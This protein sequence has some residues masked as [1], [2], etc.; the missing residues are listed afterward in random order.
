MHVFF[1]SKSKGSYLK[2]I[3]CWVLMQ[4]HNFASLVIIWRHRAMTSQRHLATNWP[5]F[6]NF[7]WKIV[8]TD[9]HIHHTHTHTHSLC[10]RAKTIKNTASVNLELTAEQW[11][12]KYEK[13]KEKNK[14]LKENIQ[15]LEAELNHWRNSEEICI[16]SLFLTQKHSKVSSEVQS[17]Q[18]L[19][20][21]E[22]VPWVFWTCSMIIL[23][24]Y[25][26][27]VTLDHKTSHEGQ[28]FLIEIY[29]SSEIWINNLSI[30]VWFVRIG[31]Y[32]AEIQLFE[33][34]ES[35]GAKK[36]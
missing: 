19:F 34:L 8:G 24:I 25:Q 15:S 32:L 4:W 2:Y 11:K 23:M 17:L 12:R 33:N 1:T 20:T 10:L 30:D 13:E 36:I 16:N 26:I 9:T 31:Q 28:F 18:L 14:N 3:C 7:L 22:N 6:S 5:S 21:H 35:E 29:T 27:Y